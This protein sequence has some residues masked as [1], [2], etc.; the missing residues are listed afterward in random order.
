MLDFL[1][2][3]GKGQFSP[4]VNTKLI[5]NKSHKI[6]GNKLMKLQHFLSWDKVT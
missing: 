2:E 5:T 4:H 1:C 6:Q 3:M